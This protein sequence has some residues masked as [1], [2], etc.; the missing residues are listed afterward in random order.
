[1]KDDSLYLHHILERCERIAI[2]IADGRE[3]FLGSTE[4]Q[5]AVIRNIEV[6]GEA[7]KRLSVETRALFPLIDWRAVCGMRDVLIHNY[8][9]VDIEE[10]WHT[11]SHDVPH[12]AAQLREHMEPE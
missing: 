4:K 11:A 10:V 9:D 1:M 2:S 8:V 6:I 3:S 7:A 5:D 12:V